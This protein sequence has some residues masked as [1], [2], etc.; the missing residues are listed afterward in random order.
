MHEFQ[1]RQYQEEVREIESPERKINAAYF[2]MNYPESTLMYG[3][4]LDRSD[5]HVYV[6]DGELHVL[7]SDG[8]HF[9]HYSGFWLPV[10]RL[11][12]SKRAY[13][14]RTNYAFA[15]MLAHM[16]SPLN[17]TTP[18]SFNWPQSGCFTARVHYESDSD[19]VERSDLLLAKYR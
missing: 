1:Y 5:R 14:E 13:P 18:D 15:L 3:Y 2:Q 4:D 17:F 12:P 9:E 16:G 10:S 19:W 8:S 11:V 7:V 6:H